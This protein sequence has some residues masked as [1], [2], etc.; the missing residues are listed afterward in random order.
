MESP[1]N[2]CRS[3]TKSEHGVRAPFWRWA[4]VMLAACIGVAGAQAQ[5]IAYEPFDY[6]A[7]SS[8][9]TWTGGTGWSGGWTNVAGG[10]GAHTATID[11]LQSPG[12]L[13]LVV[14]GRAARL[15]PSG[16]YG[17]I[18][19]NL[20]T[21]IQTSEGDL[22]LSFLVQL[23]DR[24]SSVCYGGISLGYSHYSTAFIG[25]VA[26]MREGVVRVR[27]S[28]SLYFSGVNDVDPGMSFSLGETV[29]LVSHITFRPGNERIELWVNPDLGAP[30]GK[31][32]SV[33]EL[34]ACSTIAGIRLTIGDYNSVV[35]DELR[36][37]RTASDVLPS[38][39]ASDF[40][41][42]GFITFEDFDAFVGSFETG[43]TRADFN[44]DGFLT[45]DDFDS[46]ASV[47][48][49]GC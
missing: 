23:N 26:Q 38:G 17:D 10:A 6:D 42:D 30:L 2:R 20:P 37:G 49:A 35:L 33:N 7:S 24:P 47:F 1:V 32:D 19:R 46:F 15:E 3:G 25:L 34:L 40:N 45:F 21:A 4:S 27:P 48:E 22:W 14:R 12:G 8:R 13:P 43:E 28:T 44:M 29:L 11:G 16:L 36:L 31:P 39:C 18:D 41:A 5:L 9:P